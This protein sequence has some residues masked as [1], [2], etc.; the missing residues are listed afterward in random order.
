MTDDCGDSGVVK[1]STESHHGDGGNER[2]EGRRKG[3][4]EAAGT[5]GEGG[6]VKSVA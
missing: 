6:E 2:A 1:S 5:E 4:K 3:E